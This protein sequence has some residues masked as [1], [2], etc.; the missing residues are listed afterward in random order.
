[1]PN[2]KI[3]LTNVSGTDQTFNSI[4]I[5][6]DSAREIDMPENLGDDL[7]TTDLPA[8]VPSTFTVTPFANDPAALAALLR[9]GLAETAASALRVI[10]GRISK[11]D[12]GLAA[13]ANGVKTF[14]K[15]LLD[16]GA[17]PADLVFVGCSI[18]SQIDFTD[19][20]AGTYTME[21]GTTDDANA[22]IEAEDVTTGDSPRAPTTPGVAAFAGARCP[23]FDIELKLT[24]SVDLNTCTAGF[25]AV[26][27][28]FMVPVPLISA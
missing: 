9:L 19:G 28:F 3:I 11:A 26:R 24:S 23:A 8:V 21:L 13:L 16:A 1:M 4:S 25:F 2:I 20:D 15:K 5:P 10:A 18:D 14:T 27:L 7:W 12:D 6:A 22:F 17:I